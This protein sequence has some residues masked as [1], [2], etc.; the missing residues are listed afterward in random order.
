MSAMRRA[1][2]Q[3]LAGRVHDFVTTVIVN[4]RR[5]RT[6]KSRSVPQYAKS[7]LGSTQH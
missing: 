6:P 4:T 7:L 3:I 1:Y 5:A 2:E